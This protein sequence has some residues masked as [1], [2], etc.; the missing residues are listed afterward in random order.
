MWKHGGI[1]FSH[2]GHPSRNTKKL[3]TQTKQ[4]SVLVSSQNFINVLKAQSGCLKELCLYIR[5]AIFHLLQDKWLA[6]VVEWY[7]NSLFCMHVNWIKIGTP[8]S[9]LCCITA[10]SEVWERE[11]CLHSTKSGM[12]TSWCDFA[13]GCASAR[14]DWRWDS[15]TNFFQFSLQRIISS[16]QSFM[17]FYKNF[18]VGVRIKFLKIL[19]KLRLLNTKYVKIKIYWLLAHIV[20]WILN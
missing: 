1:I 17:I 6:L 20:C 4:F 2:W 13:L 18:W 7:A 12:L 16:W 10:C 9:A 15:D 8:P 14:V 11:G 19:T 5:N 3:K